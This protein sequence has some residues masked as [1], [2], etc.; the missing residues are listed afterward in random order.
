[1]KINEI[2]KYLSEYFDLKNFITSVDPSQ[3]GLQVDAEKD[4]IKIATAVDACMETF[5]EAVA[6]QA[7]LLLVHHGLF[8]GKSLLINGVHGERI[9]YLMQNNLSLY[10]MH[11][12]LDIHHEIG[13]N[14]QLAIALGLEIV[15]P[16]G[17]Y[18]GISVGIEAK[19]L[20][21][22][23]LNKFVTKVKKHLNSVK[24]LNFGPKTIQNIAIVSG[25]GASE[26][27]AL[28]NK[29]LDLLLTGEGNHSSYHQA[30]DFGT[31]VLYAGHYNTEIYGIRA[32]GQHLQ[33]KF[34]LEHVFID[35][36]TGF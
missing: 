31:N 26:I 11:I 2:V 24:L 30:K 10:A 18:N 32:L 21:P 7:Q 34:S 9:R 3:N 17:N 14:V 23:A 36:P 16:F 35:K 6:L 20:A 28:A 33:E 1:M 15:R 27:T 4:V 22:I 13:N 5:K 19:T 8:W 29:N 25:S 12:P